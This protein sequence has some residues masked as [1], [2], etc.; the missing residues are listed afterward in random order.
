MIDL[1]ITTWRPAISSFFL[2]FPMPLPCGRVA[3]KRSSLQSR[4]PRLLFFP[5]PP[6]RNQTPCPPENFPV[7]LVC[8]TS[9][10]PRVVA[11]DSRPGQGA[12]PGPVFVAPLD[13]CRMS[14]ATTRRKNCGL[15]LHQSGLVVSQILF[16]RCLGGKGRWDSGLLHPVVLVVDQSFAH[17]SD[18]DVRILQFPDLTWL[19]G[20]QRN[21]VLL[22]H[23][24]MVGVNQT[25]S[26]RYYRKSS[27][28]EGGRE[29]RTAL[30]L[31]QER[32]V[33]AKINLQFPFG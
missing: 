14:R 17:Q 16:Q 9:A 19:K 23:G 21:A 4:P 30:L 27:H 29:E 10:S 31:N 6:S 2:L 11:A 25:I 22:Q 33:F 5:A 15:R 8:S 32:L 20:L 12:E 13:L 26:K 24:G 7:T 3:S 28:F 18:L 1:L